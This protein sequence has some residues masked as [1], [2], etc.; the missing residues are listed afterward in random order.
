MKILVVDDHPVVRQAIHGVLKRLSRDAVVLEAP[1]GSQAIKTVAEH[2][3]IALILLDLSLPDRSGLSILDELRARF[4]DVATVVL[5]ARRAWHI[6]K[7][8]RSRRRI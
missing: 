4:P 7:T 3:D 2:P 8:D 5:S 6:P 1:N